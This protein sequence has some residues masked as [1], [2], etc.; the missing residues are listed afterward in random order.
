[1]D[2]AHRLNGLKTM[3]FL[4]DVHR[5]GESIEWHRFLHFYARISKVFDN[6][7][8]EGKSTESVETDICFQYRQ[9]AR[10]ARYHQY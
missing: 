10:G 2:C 7:Q 6:H 3:A 9:I 4:H 8:P 1:M 5:S